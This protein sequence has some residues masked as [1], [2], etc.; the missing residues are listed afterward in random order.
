MDWADK[1]NA[2][3]DLYRAGRESRNLWK[4]IPKKVH[5]GVNDAFSDSDGYWIFLDHE[6]GGWVAYDGGEDCGM[7][8]EYTIADLREAIKT[9]RKGS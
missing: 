4:Y 9:I 7:I 3:A 1:E 5:E 6:I 2:Y 8:H